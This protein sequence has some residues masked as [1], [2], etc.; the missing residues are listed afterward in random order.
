M[1]TR[2]WFKVRTEHPST[3]QIS[4]SKS[5]KPSPELQEARQSRHHLQ[6]QVQQ[7]QTDLQRQTDLQLQ[8]QQLQT[9]MQEL[10]QQL[11]D[12]ERTCPICLGPPSQPMAGTCGHIYCER[13]IDM[14]GA[15]YMHN[16]QHDTWAIMD[17]NDAL[18]A[19][20]AVLPYDYYTVHPCCPICKKT[21]VFHRIY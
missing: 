14:A 9:D 18:D 17:A 4:P 19:V 10:N 8:V 3:P 1:K 20:A 11:L 16:D 13:C 5:P 2:N 15:R 21:A 12:M 7:L 6:V